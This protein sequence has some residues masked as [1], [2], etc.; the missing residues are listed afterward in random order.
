MR[1]LQRCQASSSRPF[2]PSFTSGTAALLAWLREV[3]ASHFLEVTPRRR[4]IGSRSILFEPIEA[5]VYYQAV[6]PDLCHPL[7]PGLM[8]RDSFVLTGTAFPLPAVH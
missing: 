6:R 5:K 4:V 2:C 3:Q 8:P 7:A 1:T